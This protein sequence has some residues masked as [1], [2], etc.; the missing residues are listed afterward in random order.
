M[1]HTYK[2][3]KFDFKE[4][5][6]CD[7]KNAIMSLRNTPTMGTDGIP[8]IV[9][10]ELAWVLAPYMSYL[11]NITF[12]TG[13]FP[14]KWKEGIVTPIFKKGQRNLKT[15]YRPVTI[16]NSLSKVVKRQLQ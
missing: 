12:R 2:L 8:T 15:N 13:K 9:L 1:I 10:K 6:F 16:T 4:I 7:T 3:G 11:I 14:L 5:D